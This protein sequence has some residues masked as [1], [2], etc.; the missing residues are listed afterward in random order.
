MSHKIRALI[1]VLALLLAACSPLPDVSRSGQKPLVSVSQT[2]ANPTRAVIVIP[3]ALASIRLYRDVFEW[4][5][6]N[7]EFLGYRFPGFDG[8]ALDHRLSIPQ[9]GARIGAYVEALDYDEVWLIGYSTGGP[10]ALE[11]AMNMDTGK[12]D[13]RVA[14]LSSAAPAP[15]AFASGINGMGDLVAAAHRAQSWDGKELWAEN[16]RT[17]L[18][19]RRHYRNDWLAAISER[20]A[21]GVRGKLSTPH[22]GLGAAHSAGLISWH[23]SDPANLEAATIGFFHGEEDPIF[24]ERTARR[25]A[26][27]VRADQFKAYRAGGHL[28]FLTHPCVLDHIKQMFE[29]GAPPASTCFLRK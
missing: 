15:A 6:P 14:L 10:V 12:R 5:L 11:A 27:D 20:A 2:S 9:A 4:D 28:L 19:G 29:T 13:V 3:G 16:Y 17:L 22:E 1:G 23:P 26:R 21:N 25:F 7:T 18:F 8:L 24:S